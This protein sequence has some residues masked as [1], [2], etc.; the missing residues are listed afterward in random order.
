M[1]YKDSFMIKKVLRKGVEIDLESKLISTDKIYFNC[2]SCGEEVVSQY[3]NFKSRK[4]YLC[5]SCTRKKTVKAVHNNMSKER[6]LELNKK[7]SKTTK[8]AMDRISPEKRKEM[9]EKMMASI[10]WDERNKKWFETMS[11]KTEDERAD[12]NSKISS[13]LNKRY[14]ESGPWNLSKKYSGSRYSTIEC[15]Y[16][17]RGVH[18]SNEMIEII[19]D[20]CG[21]NFSTIRMAAARQEREHPGFIQCSNCVNSSRSVKEKEVVAFIQSLGV[22]DIVENSRSIIPPQELDVYLPNYNIAIEFNGLYWHSEQ[23]GTDRLYH[24]NK[25]KDCEDV[26]VRLIHIFQDDWEYKQDIVKAR[27]KNLLGFNTRRIGARKTDVR[28]IDSKTKNQFLEKYHIQGRDKAQIKLGAYYNEELIGVMTFSKG[29][30]FGGKSKEDEWELSRFA[31]V[32]DTYTPG[33]ASKML[34]HFEK[35]YDWNRIHSF[36]DRCWSQGGL[37]ESLGFNREYE[38]PPSYWYAYNGSSIREH[39]YNYRKQNLKKFEDYD[40][41][42]TEKQIMD[43]AGYLRIYDCGTYKFSKH[44]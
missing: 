4:H 8:R 16:F 5:V 2:Q 30:L 18:S 24:I 44:I 36:A 35:N 22:D 10:N 31:T 3:S 28:E 13:S 33:L 43:D 15:K 19:C 25:T 26:G 39:R 40:D 20:R 21:K 27:L 14:K 6:R 7:I 37:Y 38:T 42:K 41:N 23:A 32:A 12:I 34:K 17:K 11:A 9:T 29:R 1:T